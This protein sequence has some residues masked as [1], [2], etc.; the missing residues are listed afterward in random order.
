MTRKDFTLIATAL[1]YSRPVN[2]NPQEPA[3]AARMEIWDATLR[4]FAR[5]LADTNPAFNRSR[6]MSAAGGTFTL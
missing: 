3:D 1:L 6:F 2:P 4:E 5:V